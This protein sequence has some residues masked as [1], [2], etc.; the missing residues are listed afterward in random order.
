MPKI[1]GIFVDLCYDDDLIHQISLKDQPQM[2]QKMV[3]SKNNK[4]NKKK[5]NKKL[6]LLLVG[7]RSFL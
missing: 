1:S 5:K 7:N 4:K 3:V 6:M 2:R